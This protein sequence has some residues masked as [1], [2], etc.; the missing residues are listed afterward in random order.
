[1]KISFKSYIL[2]IC[3]FFAGIFASTSVLAGKINIQ[4]HEENKKVII[5]VKDATITDV[6][7]EIGKSFQINV[8]GLEENR[9]NEKISVK[10]EG[11][12]KSILGRL[13]KNRNY[14]IVHSSNNKNTIEKLVIL[15]SNV[16]SQPSGQ[17]IQH[18]NQK[19]RS[20]RIQRI[21]NAIRNKSEGSDFFK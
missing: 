13:L 5:D 12:L 1:M 8:K 21:T 3:Y 17:V 11:N 16:G 6:L 9:T 2:I 19:K 18:L 20:R 7:D 15:N 10:Y 4:K 14:L